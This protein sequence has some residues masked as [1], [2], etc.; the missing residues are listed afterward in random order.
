MFVSEK[1]SGKSQPPNK[2][3]DFEPTT[4]NC[5]HDENRR[6][7]LRVL[8]R[9]QKFKKKKRYEFEARGHRIGRIFGSPR[10]T[11]VQS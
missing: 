1:K 3:K 5:V 11:K 9:I 4:T 8:S 2:K 7:S 10:S 6:F